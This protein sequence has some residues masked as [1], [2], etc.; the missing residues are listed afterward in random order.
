[1]RAL[2]RLTAA[3]GLAALLAPTASAQGPGFGG[4]GMGNVPPVAILAVPAVQKEL[5][6]D[7]S[8]VS[9]ATAL[10][11]EFRDKR[12]E[13]MQGA[14]DLEP[15]ERMAKMQE[16]NK[17]L[18]ADA[19][20]SLADLLK[21]EQRKRFDQIALQQRGAS[22]LA[23]P[24]VADALKLTG[25]Q[26]AKVRETMTESQGKMQEIFQSAGGDREAMREKMTAFRKEMNDK[27]TAVLTADQKKAHQEMLGAP[28]EMP[29]MRPNR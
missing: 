26:K 3:F 29:D 9:K 20:K 13:A 1:M 10:A 25:D 15:Q 6:L 17:T 2:A 5:K 4:M 22:A 7:D 14:Q 16:V 18:A 27:L 11:A 21:P 28:F 8:Q 23:D 12:R 19:K 24:E